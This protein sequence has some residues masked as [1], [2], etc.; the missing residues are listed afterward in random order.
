MRAPG[1]TVSNCSCCQ[2]HSLRSIHPFPE[3]SEDTAALELWRSVTGWSLGF[4][5]EGAACQR[6][7]DHTPLLV[8]LNKQFPLILAAL[9]PWEHSFKGS[10]WS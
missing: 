7:E 3:G 9:A 5:E 2:R 1:E 6:G 4:L 10:P 8:L